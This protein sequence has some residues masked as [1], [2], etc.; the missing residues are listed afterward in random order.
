MEYLRALFGSF[1]ADAD[2]VEV[3]SMLAFSLSIG[4]H[5]IAAD[6]GA[7]SREECWR[8]PWH[9]CWP[10]PAVSRQDRQVERGRAARRRPGSRSRRSSRPGREAHDREGA[11]SRVVTS[12]AAPLTSAGR[13]TA[14]SRAKV[15]AWP[16]TASAPRTSL[17]SAAAADVGAQHHVRVE[18]ATSASKSPSRAARQERVDDLALAVEV[19][20]GHGAAPLHA[21][22]G[23][24][25]ELACGVGERPTIGAISSNGMANMSCSTNASRSAG[26]SVSS[27]TSS[28][29]PTESARS[30]SCSG[31]VPSAAID[32]RLGHVH[33]HRLLAPRLRE[34]SMFRHTRATTVVSQPRRFSMSLGVGA[35]EPQP[36]L[37]HGVVGLAQR[38]EHAVG[39]RAQVRA[40]LLE[41]LG[42]PILFVQGHI[43]R[44]VGSTRF[45][46]RDLLDVTTR[47]NR[48][49]YGGRARQ[50]NQ[51]GLGAS[52]NQ[53]LS[54]PFV[55]RRT[56]SR[57]KP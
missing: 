48:T 42:Q 31:S 29:S 21:P 14:P 40:V 15:R 16:A 52:L 35:A 19:G 56:T 12:P 34:R 45:D 10:R 32:D 6:H 13:A 49:G 41:E 43:L 55:E 11:P 8:W 51:P 9:G 28:A 4:D 24:A 17:Q 47:P 7:R 57:S 2:D 36:R 5:F 20:V 46:P 26:A 39:D 18:H 54:D 50:K 22:A 1:C 53:W 38:A 30:A 33:V 3:R 23:A 44:H 25:R 37:L 27:T